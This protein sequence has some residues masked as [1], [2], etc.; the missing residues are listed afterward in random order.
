MKDKKKL[1]LKPLISVVDCK[2][3]PLEGDECRRIRLLRQVVSDTGEP[4]P[5]VSALEQFVYD[6]AG[7]MVGYEAAQSAELRHS[8]S[9]RIRWEGGRGKYKLPKENDEDSTEV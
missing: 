9:G 7:V 1:R 5:L 3:C 2:R 8:L 4:C 6:E